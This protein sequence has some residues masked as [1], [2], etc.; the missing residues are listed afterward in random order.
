MCIPNTCDYVS[1]NLK[2]LLYETHLFIPKNKQTTYHMNHK[3][4]KMKYKQN[5]PQIAPLINRVQNLRRN[6]FLLLILGVIFIR[7]QL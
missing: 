5:L 1:T 4:P 6:H 2:E 7:Y 3:V